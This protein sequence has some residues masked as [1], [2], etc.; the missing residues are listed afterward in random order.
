ERLGLADDAARLVRELPYGRQ[1]LVEIAVALSLKPHVLLLDEP[2]AGVPSA[3]SGVIV[4]VIESL[5]PEIAVLIIEHD[6]DLVFRL[7]RRITVLVQGAIL[8]EGTPEEI[9]ADPRVRE[10]YLGERAPA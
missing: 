2:A 10:V 5:P 6:M 4:D 1:R 3:E 9:A 7:A 8:V